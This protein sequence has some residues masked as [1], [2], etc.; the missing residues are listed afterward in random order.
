MTSLG[1]NSPKVTTPVTLFLWLRVNFCRD[2]ARPKM[3][4]CMEHTKQSIFVLDDF[5]KDE[6]NLRISASLSSLIK[7]RIIL[8]ILKSKLLNHIIF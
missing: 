5:F 2:F 3:E 8:S 6:T 4:M 7:K 1:G